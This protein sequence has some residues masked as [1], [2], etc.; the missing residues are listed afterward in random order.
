MEGLGA[1]ARAHGQGLREGT[2]DGDGDHCGKRRYTREL[3]P[4]EGY[5][6]E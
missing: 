3:G 2:P 4:N 5:D 6:S 1:T